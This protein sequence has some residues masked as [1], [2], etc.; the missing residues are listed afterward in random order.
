MNNSAK[1]VSKNTKLKCNKKNNYKETF[2]RNNL[3]IQCPTLF[4]R[5]F[6]LSLIIFTLKIKSIKVFVKISSC[7]LTG[8]DVEHKS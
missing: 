1:I 8:T 2:Q 4:S 7:F 5:E 6:N 3:H